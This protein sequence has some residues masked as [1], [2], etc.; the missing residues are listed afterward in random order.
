M[1][2]AAEVVT[3]MIV[4]MLENN[5][6]PWHQPW[7]NGGA[8]SVNGNYYRGINAI[9]L[10]FQ[11][12][13]DNRWLT[14]NRAQALGGRVR[15]GEKSIPAVFWQFLKK[16]EKQE[17]GSIKT[18]TIPFAKTYYVFN[19]EQCEG[20]N[21]GPCK[22]CNRNNTP[23]EEAEKVW[24]GY[25]DKPELQHNTSKAFY[26]P[27]GDYISIPNIKQFKSSEEYYS[28]LFH[29][30]AHSTGSEKRLNRL[31][32]TSFGSEEYGKEELIAEIAA[33]I[34]CQHCGITRTLENSV[35]Y[36]QSWAKA[37]KAMPINAVLNAASAA[38]KAVDHILGI[39]FEEHAE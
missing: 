24:N 4:K 38:Q 5:V 11:N 25:T 23:L 7:I 28:T 6:S 34:L 10:G 31:T 35:A 18:V 21:I 39:K 8:M 13:G 36:C 19:V 1:K 37:I 30:A 20:L 27:N 29:E 9:L 14:F 33:Q 2:K 32:S 26:T 22:A 16:E 3:E 17:D 12:Y 15:K